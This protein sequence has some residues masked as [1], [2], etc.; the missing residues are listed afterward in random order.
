VLASPAR[1]GAARL[2]LAISKKQARRAIDRNRLKRLIRET[3]RRSRDEL[4]G[5][6]L[7]VMARAVALGVDNRRLTASLQRHFQRLRELV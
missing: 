3:F 7:V 1:P 2:G 4:P 5:V 6:D